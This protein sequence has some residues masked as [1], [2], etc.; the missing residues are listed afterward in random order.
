ML[1]VNFCLQDRAN[2]EPKPYYNDDIGSDLAEK[3][4]LL[5]EEYKWV[6]SK[7]WRI[8]NLQQLYAHRKSRSLLAQLKGMLKIQKPG[9]LTN[10]TIYRVNL[11][12]T[13]ILKDVRRFVL[14]V[15]F[16]LELY[17]RKPRTIELWERN[18]N[19]PIL[20]LGFLKLSDSGL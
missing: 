14:K 11:E 16:R 1:I 7:Q 3:I 4:I 20:I 9:E 19:I 2:I 8:L 10:A 12:R 13:S 18:R 5:L 17:F 6:I 15:I